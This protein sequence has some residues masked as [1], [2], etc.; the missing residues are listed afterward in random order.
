VQ[1]KKLI[2]VGDSVFA[3]V[4][5]EFFQWDSGYE[6]V[7]FTV[8]RQF[9]GR[10]DIQGVPVVA[11][12]D[13]EA[14]YPPST[15]SAFVAIVFTQFNRLRTR[16][17]RECKAK[18]YPMASYISSAALIRPNC[19]IGEHCFICEQTVIQP[20]TQVGN[21]VVIWSGNQICHRCRIGDN[22]FVLPN[23]IVSDGVTIG[24]NG[25]VGANVT[26]SSDRTIGKDCFIGPATFIERDVVDGSVIERIPTETAPEIPA[27]K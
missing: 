13:L 22:T 15:H 2:L 21:N 24:E 23:C 12:E 1:K 14:L 17:Y 8:E 20:F 4:A 25:I 11:F 5:L 26:F 27:L 16:L 18:G 7:A 3:Q 10:T 6:V 19:T 9:L